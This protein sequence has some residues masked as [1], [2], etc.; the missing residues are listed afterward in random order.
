MSKTSIDKTD[1]KILNISLTEYND[2]VNTIKKLKKGKYFVR[3][4]AVK[5]KKGKTTLLYHLGNKIFFQC[6]HELP[7][8]NLYL[9]LFLQ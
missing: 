1:D 4:R 3:V 7:N 5:K 9:Y 6:Q 8:Y 2:L